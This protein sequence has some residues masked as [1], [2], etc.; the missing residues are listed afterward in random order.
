MDLENNE[1]FENLYSNIDKVEDNE[2]YNGF[3][4]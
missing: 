4:R 3:R 2:K 1:I